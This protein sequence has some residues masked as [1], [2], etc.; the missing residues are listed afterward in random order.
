MPE[1]PEEFEYGH[2]RLFA[3]TGREPED[4]AYVGPESGPDVDRFQDRLKRGKIKLCTVCGDL[5]H[6]SSRMILSPTAAIM[7]VI[8]GTLHLFLYG[9]ATK[10]FQTPW[11]LEFVLPALY[12]MGSVFIGVG[13]VF[14][15]IR[16]RVWRCSKCGEIDKR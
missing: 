6:R 7:L 3:V 8:F 2:G 11:Y 10:V 13:V 1:K 5:M 14:F 9:A 15:F 4:A 12:Y 16:E